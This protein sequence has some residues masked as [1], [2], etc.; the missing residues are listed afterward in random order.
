MDR[1]SRA[2]RLAPARRKSANNGLMHR[3]NSRITLL[4]VIR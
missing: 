3:S 1:F 4:G 2:A